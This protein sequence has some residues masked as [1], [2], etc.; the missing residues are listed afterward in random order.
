MFHAVGHSVM[1]EDSLSHKNPQIGKM[2]YR[3][4][5]QHT[6][7]FHVCAP[8]THIYVQT[9]KQM[10]YSVFD[11]SEI[12]CVLIPRLHV[13]VAG[14]LSNKSNEGNRSYKMH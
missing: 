8:K 1:A 5:R 11:I 2:G 4:C 13:Y 10:L 3:K 9:V 7:H 12:K 6:V 14:N